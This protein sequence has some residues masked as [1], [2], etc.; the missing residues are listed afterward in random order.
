MRGDEA[1]CDYEGM[2]TAVGSWCG[3]LWAPQVI[4]VEGEECVCRRSGEDRVGCV[5]GDWRVIRECRCQASMSYLDTH[6][7]LNT[8]IP[9][10]F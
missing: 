5:N 2:L 1:A 6:P 7:I 8:E 4:E 10:E 9:T 3:V